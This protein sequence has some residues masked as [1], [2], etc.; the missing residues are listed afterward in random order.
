M[1]SPARAT[2]RTSS[3]T[4]RLEVTPKILAFTTWMEI[5]GTFYSLC[6]HTYSCRTW[7]PSIKKPL[8]MMA[9]WHN[10]D[11][12]SIIHQHCRVKF[13]LKFRGTFETLKSFYSSNLTQSY[14]LFFFTRVWLYT[15]CIFAFMGFQFRAI[16][17]WSILDLSWVLIRVK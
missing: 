1:I 11:F 10:I 6:R 8:M 9:R 16:L 7:W 4:G 17:I 2:H 14:L 13:V 15:E 5:G 3:L 12:S